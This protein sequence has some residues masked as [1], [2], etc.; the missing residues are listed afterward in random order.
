[1]LGLLG[2]DQFEV[3]VPPWFGDVVGHKFP[4]TTAY[5]NGNIAYAKSQLGN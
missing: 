2:T 1:V 5:L 4:D 3:Y